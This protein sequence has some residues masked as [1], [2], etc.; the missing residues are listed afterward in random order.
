LA[1]LSGGLYYVVKSAYEV[2]I[3]LAGFC[4][5]MLA[6]WPDNIAGGCAGRRRKGVAM[7]LRWRVALA[8]A[9]LVL[10]LVSLAV[11]AYVFWPFQPLRQQFQPPPTLF[12]PPQSA[13]VLRLWM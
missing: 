7:V 9:G 11:M 3:D 4:Q 10:V 6:G 1:L 5:A 12:V 8:L 13:V 2:I